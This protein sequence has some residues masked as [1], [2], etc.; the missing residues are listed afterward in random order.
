MKEYGPNITPVSESDKLE[1]QEIKIENGFTKWFDNFWFYNKWKVII[2]LFAIVLVTVC[3][4]QTCGNVSNDITVMYA[5][6]LYITDKTAKEIEKVLNE[7]MPRDFN[8]D[9]EKISDIA[10]LNIYSAEQINERKEQ[11][12]NDH[13]VI[14]INGYANGQELSSFDNLVT[15]GE[16][17]L[18]LLEDWLY[19]RIAVGGAVRRLDDIF[20]TDG[21]PENAIDSYAIR[22][23]DTDFAKKYAEEFKFT[24]KNTVLCLRTPVSIG[25]VLNGKKSK[26]NYGY[27]EEMFRAIV[28]LE[29]TPAKTD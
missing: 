2:A 20:G 18:C 26:R 4:L 16:Y 7:V 12:K 5:G 8:G 13:S 15:T 22:F 23:W 29:Y 9:G 1:A 28:E 25:S 21:V 14:E 11:A 24:P 3:V 10:A 17:S 19:E 6:S 27:A